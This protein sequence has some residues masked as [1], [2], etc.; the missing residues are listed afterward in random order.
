[1]QI[2]HVSS[3]C[4]PA[5][6]AGGLGDVAGAL[7]KYLTKASITTGVVL[8]KYSTKWINQQEWA[9]VF[10]DSIDF[11]QVAVPFTVQQWKGK[12]TFPLFVVDI[13][14]KYDRPGVYLNEEGLGLSLIH[15]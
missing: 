14:G 10:E 6:K 7:P 15:I 4:Y 2:L 13:P 8:P 11:Y 12:S 3:E 9:T 5:A 1:M